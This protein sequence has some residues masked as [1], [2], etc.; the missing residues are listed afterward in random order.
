MNFHGFGGLKADAQTY[1]AAMFNSAPVEHEVKMSWGNR[2][3]GGS[4]DNPFL[5][6]QPKFNSYMETVHPQ[7]ICKGLMDIREQ[8]CV[9]AHVCLHPYLLF[10]CISMSISI[11]YPYHHPDLYLCPQLH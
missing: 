10:I 7:K 5:Q 3:A 9:C 6:D 4:K 8:V 11:P 2:L 1:L